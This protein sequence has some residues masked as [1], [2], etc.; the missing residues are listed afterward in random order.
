M[1]EMIF[2]V[3]EISKKI[4]IYEFLEKCAFILCEEL[5]MFVRNRQGI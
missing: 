5:Q 3:E 2:Q 4:I 1:K